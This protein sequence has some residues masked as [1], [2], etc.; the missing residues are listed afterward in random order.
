MSQTEIDQL[1]NHLAQIIDNDTVVMSAVDFSHNLISEQAQ[2]N[3]QL[4]YELMQTHQ[5][6]KLR[7]LGNQYLDSSPAII[8]LLMT[9]ELVGA[10]RSDLLYNT[11][12]G[13][14]QG[15]YSVGTT[16]YFSIIYYK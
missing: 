11:N 6:T 5:Y 2:K 9:M 8:V 13:E 7:N 3:D 15:D 12:S 10:T 14:M 1:T 16:S 4:T